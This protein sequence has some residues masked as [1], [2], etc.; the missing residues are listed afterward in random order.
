MHALAGATA[1]RPIIDPMQ[2]EAI[3]IEAVKVA[4]SSCSLREICLPVGLSEAD[5]DQLDSLIGSRR[6]VK[7][8]G[9][10]FRAGD[11]FEALYAV[12]TGFFKTRVSAEDGRDQVT[13]FQMAGELLGLDGISTDRH[14][15]DAVALEDSQVCQIP[16]G[17]LER[18]SQGSPA[19]Q[20]QQV[21]A[22]CS[23]GK[24]PWPTQTTSCEHSPECRILMAGSHP[25]RRDIVSKRQQICQV[26]YFCPVTGF[27]LPVRIRM[28]LR[29]FVDESVR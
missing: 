11:R 8:G 1:L 20:H 17:E 22:T 13:G 2:R 23:P 18:L 16:Y 12:R 21:K 19:L 14:A 28:G 6:T 27:R 9:L 25:D 4:C 15:C 29:I 24:E 3:R 10:L 26:T 7:R 5:L